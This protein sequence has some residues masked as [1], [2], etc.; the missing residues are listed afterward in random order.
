MRALHDVL[1]FGG[2]AAELVGRGRSSYDGDRQLRLAGEAIIIRLGEAAG[3]L[4]EA[5]VDDHPEIAFRPLRGM[6]NLVAHE[7]H[8]TDPAVLWATLQ[9]A[10]PPL[11]DQV[12]A[13]L[14]TEDPLT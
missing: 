12:A 7:Y 8:R 13:L 10:L 3:R 2:M 4:S 14:A 5:L 9:D 11:L 1:E 6:R